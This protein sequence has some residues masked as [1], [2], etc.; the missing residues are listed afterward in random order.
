MKLMDMAGKWNYLE[1]A[2]GEPVLVADFKL[3]PADFQVVEEL[4]FEPDG[5]GEHLW[6]YIEK[7]GMTTFE[8][9]AVLARYFNL[10]L[11]NTAFSGMKDRQGI[12][13]QWF[14]FHLGIH[15]HA[16]ALNFQH[17]RLTILRVMSNSRKLRRGSHRSNGFC[18]TLR[19][20]QGDLNVCMARLQLLTQQGVPNYFG[21]QRFGKDEGNVSRALDWFR[22]TI[23]SPERKEQSLLLSAARSFLFN[24]VLSERVASQNWNTCIEG[25]VMA[26]AGTASIFASGRASTEEL[27]Q[28][29]ALLDIHPTG[30]LWGSGPLA[31]TSVAAA[32]ERNVANRFPELLAGLE[33]HGLVQERRALRLKINN[34]KSHFNDT[35][36][37]LEFSLERGA[38][39]T[40]VL[41]ELC[42]MEVM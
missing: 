7:T 9:Q 29:L 2:W 30:P 18:I 36:L 14:S 28:R 6:L 41:R 17:P 35:T 13:R 42:V 26:L 5:V 27:V 37:Q 32:Q 4:G 19:N 15:D 8:A 10:Q 33:S 20:F 12:T 16:A 11:R 1:R 24:T 34:L 38:Y 40:T 23:K 31:T 3:E 25:D 22:G 21:S 39:A